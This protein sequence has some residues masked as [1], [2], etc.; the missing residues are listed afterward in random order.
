VSTN[1]THITIQIY[2]LV[3]VCL[4]RLGKGI[5]SMAQGQDVQRSGSHYEGR[6]EPLGLEEQNLLVK[7]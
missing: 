4:D 5:K 6:D 3:E 7:E 2:H 1:S